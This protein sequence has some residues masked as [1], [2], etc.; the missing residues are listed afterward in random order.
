MRQ[1]TIKAGVHPDD[2]SGSAFR[3][4]RD[5]RGNAGRTLGDVTRNLQGAVALHQEGEN[6]AP[7]ELS[8]NPTAVV[9]TE[10]PPAAHV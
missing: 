9:T 3:V 4:S 1:Q 5:R 6:L 10:L 2:E 7:L 8:P